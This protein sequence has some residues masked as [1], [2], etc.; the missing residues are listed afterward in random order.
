MVEEI[1]LLEKL[2]STGEIL[3]LFKVSFKSDTFSSRETTLISAVD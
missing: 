3:A 1:V 2:T